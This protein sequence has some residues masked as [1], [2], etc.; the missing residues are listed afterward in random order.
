MD[1]DQEIFASAVSDEPIS[2]PEP[3][4]APEPVA[5][6]SQ[7]EPTGQSRD[8]RGRFAAAEGAP[9]AAEAPPA[10]TPGQEQQPTGERDAHIPAWRLREVAE[11]RNKARERAEQAERRAAELEA[12][13]RASQRQQTPQEPPKV[14]DIFEDP[15][16][17]LEHGV[18]QALSPVQSEVAQLREFYS[19]REAVREHGAE[20][21]DKAYD[22]IEQALRSGDPEANV[23]FLRAQR[24][25][26][27]FGEIVTWHQK[28]SVLREIG[29]D[30]NAWFEKRMEAML[31]DPAQKAKLLERASGQAPP[32]A[33]NAARPGTTVQLPPSLSRIP[34]AAPALGEAGD[35]SDASLFSNA[36]R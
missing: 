31:A 33:P 28:N 1:T 34:S 18:K 19:R 36:L 21:V 26:D 4:A 15:N 16:A 20:T 27:P 30:P 32:P 2:Q 22:A 5:S 17:F 29:T 9:P 12:H 13:V 7:P 8:E 23:A 3:E 35:M 10:P 24:S 14:P 11:E 25:L 6:E